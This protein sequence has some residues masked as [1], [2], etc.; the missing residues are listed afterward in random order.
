MTPQQQRALGLLAGRTS[1]TLNDFAKAMWPNSSSWQNREC[2]GRGVRMNAVVLLNRM[3][4]FGWCGSIRDHV[5]SISTKGLGE[6]NLANV[7]TQ[8][9]KLQRIH[10]QTRPCRSTAG[11]EVRNW[12]DVTCP[13]CKRSNT[14]RQR[15]TARRNPR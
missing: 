2:P 15:Q 1:V 4:G 3:Q 8:T 9:K 5:Y 11:R 6:L 7:T 10:H 14:L 12:R 13:A